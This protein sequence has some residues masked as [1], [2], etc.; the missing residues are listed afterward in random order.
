MC[1][2]GWDVPMWVEFS[3]AIPDDT[4]LLEGVTVCV[5]RMEELVFKSEHERV[6]PFWAG[7]EGFSS[8]LED[9]GRP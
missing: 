5:G 6:A 2:C 4:L 1:P 8:S 9:L 3:H 7:N